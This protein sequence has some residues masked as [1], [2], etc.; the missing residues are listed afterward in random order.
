MS[1]DT[2]DPEVVLVA[3]RGR[4][5]ALAARLGTPPKSLVRE[6]IQLGAGRKGGT[7][8]M[9]VDLSSAPNRLRAMIERRHAQLME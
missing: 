2:D 9:C 3:W 5:S 4:A 1:D 8:C 7:I 6:L